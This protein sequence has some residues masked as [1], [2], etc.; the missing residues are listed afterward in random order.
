MTTNLTKGQ[1]ELIQLTMIA[2]L[3]AAGALFQVPVDILYVV[4]PICVMIGFTFS[5]GYMDEMI[6]T[7]PDMNPIKAKPGV[8]KVATSF[9]GSIYIFIRAVPVMFWPSWYLVIVISAAEAVY[10]FSKKAKTK[11]S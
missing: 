8:F 9:F 4:V 10:V 11:K 1:Y 2:V 5:T 3:M 7:I 6:K